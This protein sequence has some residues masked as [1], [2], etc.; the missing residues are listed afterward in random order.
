MQTV[1]NLAQKLKPLA[2]ICH[3]L[4]HLQKNIYPRHYSRRWNDSNI[5]RINR[6]D[7]LGQRTDRLAQENVEFLSTRVKLSK[8]NKS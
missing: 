5:G 2:F 8:Q 7:R 4:M 3:T 1:Q 6:N